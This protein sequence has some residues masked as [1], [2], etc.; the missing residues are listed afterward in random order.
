MMHPMAETPLSVRAER[1][2]DILEQYYLREQKQVSEPTSG[3][4]HLRVS[5]SVCGGN[6]PYLE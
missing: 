1:L 4:A 5:S 3:K 6:S 2:H